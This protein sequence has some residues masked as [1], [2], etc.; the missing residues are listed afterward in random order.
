MG[1]NT[2]MLRSAYNIS[3]RDH[4]TIHQIYGKLPRLT[5]VVRQR[6]LMLAGH[7]ARHNEP[8]GK[9]LIWCPEESRRVGRPKTTLK[10]ILE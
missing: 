6:R 3:W 1:P 8:A 10:M 5:T 7:V 4:P 2:S 9:L